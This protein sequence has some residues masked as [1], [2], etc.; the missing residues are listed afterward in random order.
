MAG[1]YIRIFIFGLALSFSCRMAGQT[2]M[3]D[4]VCMGET[5]HYYVDA[6]PG[7]TYTWRIDGVVQAGFTGNEFEHTWNAADTF[8]LDVQE[9]SADGCPGPV[10]SGL[11]YVKPLQNT[12]LIIQKAFSPNGDLINDV[13]NIGNIFLFPK[14]EVTI[15]NRWGQSVWKSGAGYPQPWNGKSNGSDLPID[16]YH[17]VINLNNGTKPI[18]GDVTI[19]R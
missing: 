1:R 19:V 17:Y 4:F 3:P 6:N 12:G 5:R 7:S 2:T 9:I 11:V 13:W 16:S 10:I 14:M 8:L 18:V 15:Y